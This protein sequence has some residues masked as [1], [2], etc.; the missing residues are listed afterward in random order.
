MTTKDESKILNKTIIPTSV[1]VSI[2][3]FFAKTTEKMI[4]TEL[5]M[6]R[7]RENE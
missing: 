6:E 5:N 7:E 1:I 4:N 2:I 3:F